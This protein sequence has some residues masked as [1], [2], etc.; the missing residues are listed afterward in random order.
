M[1]RVHWWSFLVNEE[2]QPIDNADISIYLAGTTIPATVYLDEFATE[3]VDE[4]PQVKSN[5]NGFFEFW[6]PDVATEKYDTNQ[7]FKVEWNKAGVEYGYIDYVDIYPSFFPVNENDSDTTK[8]KTVSNA[9]AKGWERHVLNDNH[10]IHGI[11]EVNE[12]DYISTIKNKTISNVLAYDWEKHSSATFTITSATSASSADTIITGTHSSSGDFPHGIEPVDLSGNLDLTDS[13][14]WI[15]N[16]LISSYYGEKWNDHSND[17]DIHGT[18]VN[19]NETDTDRNKFVSNYLINY[20]LYGVRYSEQISSTDWSPSG[21][22]YI[23]DIQ[24]RLD[25]QYP[26]IQMWDTDTNILT[27]SPSA[28]SLGPSG[29]RLENDININAKI[30]I[31]K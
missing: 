18:P 8:D 7:K 21:S 27:R 30:I 26:S 3:V 22:T 15:R 23:V 10:I 25:E 17:E 14:Y 19:E 24:H 5:Q 2:G 11:Q 4:T 29:I 6:V 16:K 28:E 12:D 1:A 31:L 9:L 20:L 13:D